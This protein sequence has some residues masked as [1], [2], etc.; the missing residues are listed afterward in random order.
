M[1]QDAKLA[2]GESEDA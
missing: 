2:E 1:T